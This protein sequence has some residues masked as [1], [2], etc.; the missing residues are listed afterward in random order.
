LNGSA[1]YI[2]DNTRSYENTVLETINKDKSLWHYLA[3]GKIPQLSEVRGKIVLIRDWGSP[4]IIGLDW[5]SAKLFSIQDK[6]EISTTENVWDWMFHG[7]D[8]VTGD[9]GEKWDATKG[10]LDEARK[11]GDDNKFY[12]S[13]A[14]GY[15][16]NPLP[17]ITDVAERLNPKVR[18]YF[19]SGANSRAKWHCIV[20][21][22]F[23]DERTIRTIIMQNLL[24]R[25]GAG[26]P[27][28]ACK[29][30]NI[31]Q[32]EYMYAAD[33]DTFDSSRRQIFT[34]RPGNYVY[35]GRWRIIPIGDGTTC[36][37][38]NEYQQEFLYASDYAT[39][40]DDRRRVFTWR[41]MDSVKQAVWKLE[42][43]GSKGIR[44][45]NTYQ[46]EYLYAAD[47]GCYDSDRRRVFTWQTKNQ[48]VK[49]GYWKIERL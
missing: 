17:Q 48:T 44:I 1:P 24:S 46:S 39:Y 3:L 5:S 47:Y 35:Q 10:K 31:A 27:G 6:Y 8:V 4:G 26:L 11:N 38:W 37:I 25:D 33:H 49:Q 45:Y 23:P 22:D 20:P 16:L 21:M 41:D 29:I 18:E 13:H 12:V 43:A 34:W 9:Y 7:E 42:D 30:Y 40:D 32:K 28:Y 14:S 19:R 36:Y 2:A 15:W